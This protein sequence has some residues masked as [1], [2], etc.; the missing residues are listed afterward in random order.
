MAG[1]IQIIEFTTTRPE[2]VKALSE[3]YRESRKASGDAAPVIRGTFT[4]DKDRPNTYLNIVEFPSYEAAMENSNHPSTSEFAE[5][6][7]VICDGP[8]KFY[9][10]DLMETW[11]A[12]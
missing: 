8:P 10:L 2:E 11:T 5:K 1:F 9:N 4:A 6:M 3:Q 7:M 12:D